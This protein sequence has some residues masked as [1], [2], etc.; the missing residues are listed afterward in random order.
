MCCNVPHSDTTG[1]VPK[2]MNIWEA[3]AIIWR[4]MVTRPHRE[5]P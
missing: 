2:K 4:E 1:P 5:A 3:I